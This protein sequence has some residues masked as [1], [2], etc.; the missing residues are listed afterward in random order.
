MSH[1]NKEVAHLWAHQVA[2]YAKGSHLSFNG[3][4]LRSYSTAIAE[5]VE[6][7]DGHRGAVL[8]CTSY[9]VTTQRHQHYARMAISHLPCVEVWDIH[10]GEAAIVPRYTKA[11]TKKWARAQIKESL[12][13]AADYHLKARRARTSNT[14]SCLNARAMAL[15]DNA[16]ALGDW[17]GVKLPAIDVASIAEKAERAYAAEAKRQRDE[18]K[19]LEKDNAKKIKAWQDGEPGACIPLRVGKVY[20]RRR[21]PG[22]PE[23]M[24]ETSKG[25][26]IPWD[27]AIKL[28]RFAQAKRK[29]GWRRNGE[30]FAVGPYQL[31]SVTE[32]GIVAGCH[33]ISFEEIERL[34]KREGVT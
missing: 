23:S 28:F 14:Q 21:N 1:N 6:L 30:T 16:T 18:Q 7:P 31:D 9:S 33:R 25:A 27:D 11:E 19:K 17:F 12:R 3:P 5:L 29:K 13:R 32:N 20:L 34:A 4:V 2:P 10:R 24:V 15:V 26:T 8:N 22:L